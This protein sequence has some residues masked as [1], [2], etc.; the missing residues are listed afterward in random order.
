M[1]NFNCEKLSV[2]KQTFVTYNQHTGKNVTFRAETLYVG[3]KNGSSSFNIS[4]NIA[5]IRRKIPMCCC[6]HDLRQYRVK[7]EVVK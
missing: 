4:K 5:D 7:Y 3:Q 1:K 2:V 6:K